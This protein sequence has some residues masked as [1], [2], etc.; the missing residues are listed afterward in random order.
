MIYK[1][2]RKSN[3]DKMG[4]HIKSK[5]KTNKNHTGHEI[6]RKIIRNR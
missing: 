6:E 1:N 4:I 3:I 2:N 5:Y